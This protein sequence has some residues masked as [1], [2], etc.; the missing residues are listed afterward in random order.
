MYR[1]KLGVL[2]VICYDIIYCY[3]IFNECANGEVIEIKQM[4]I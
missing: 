4:V 2:T 1:I 3:L